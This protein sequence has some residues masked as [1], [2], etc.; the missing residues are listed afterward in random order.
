MIWYVALVALVNLALGYGLALLLGNK[1]SDM[2]LASG[3]V[4]SD[5]APQF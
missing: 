4:D 1:R 3:A 2:A 5:D